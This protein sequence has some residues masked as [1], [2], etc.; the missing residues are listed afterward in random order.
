MLVGSEI[1]VGMDYGMGDWWGKSDEENLKERGDLE[2]EYWDGG[3]E[4][5]E[6]E[7]VDDEVSMNLIKI[8]MEKL[9]NEIV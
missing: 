8:M 7:V 9:V 5:E 3:M 1:L 2:V 6:E 4:E